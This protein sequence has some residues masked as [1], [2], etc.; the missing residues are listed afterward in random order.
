M[1]KDQLL[2][3]HTAGSCY[4]AHALMDHILWVSALIKI[5]RATGQAK[6]NISEGGLINMQA[7]LRTDQL[8]DR[9]CP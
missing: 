4:R 9:V 6:A 7:E 5:H 8:G 2:T 3:W 1:D